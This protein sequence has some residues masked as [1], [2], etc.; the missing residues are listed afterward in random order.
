MI[1]SVQS[2]RTYIVKLVL[3][4]LPQVLGRT[5]LA[6]AFGASITRLILVD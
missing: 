4:F 1:A 6:D 2:C 3:L 5:S